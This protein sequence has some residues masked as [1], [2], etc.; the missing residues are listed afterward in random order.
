MLLNGLSEY[1][2]ITGWVNSFGTGGVPGVVWIPSWY[3]PEPSSS[4]SMPLRWLFL[5]P[6]PAPK[7]PGD[8][9]GCPSGPPPPTTTF[10][11]YPYLVV[12]HYPPTLLCSTNEKLPPR[13]TTQ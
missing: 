13:S 4:N 2:G 6:P 12:L 7:L 11:L 9:R 10:P 3:H 8:P 1:G 5:L